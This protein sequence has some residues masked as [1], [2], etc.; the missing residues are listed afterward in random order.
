MA[1][2][3]DHTTLEAFN[4]N[5]GRIDALRL[6]DELCIGTGDIAAI[7]DKSAR[8]VRKNPEAESMQPHLTR[9][10][11][12]VDT[13]RRN[14]GGDLGLVRVWLRAPH[15]DLDNEAPL[16]LIRGGEVEAVESLAY[17]IDS[18]MPG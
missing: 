14:L 9:V 12:I 6:A 13:L 11:A 16:D 10:L 17:S 4:R 2:I 5:T 1:D 15:P 8:Y 18:G 3:L 7:V